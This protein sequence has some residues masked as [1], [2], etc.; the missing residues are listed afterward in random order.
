MKTAILISGQART[1]N[2]CYANQN[3]M[4][5]RSLPDPHFFVSVA[6]DEDA[7]S[8][9]LL[10]KDWP[11]DR[12]HAERLD[13]PEHI[14][15]PANIEEL[16]EASPCPIAQHTTVQ[17]ILK[18]FWHL[19]RVWQ[20]AMENANVHSFDCVVRIRPDI[21]FHSAPA[22]WPMPKEGRCLTPWWSRA[23][24]TN[25][26]FAIL[27]RG[28]ANAYFTTLGWAQQYGWKHGYP[29][30]PESMLYFGLRARSI[31]LC[32]MLPTTFSTIRKD[33][34]H[35]LPDPTLADIADLNITLASFARFQND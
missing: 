33:G 35:I 17:A 29:I 24:G 28:A 13:Q 9:Q 8:V 31:I 21:K 22:F 32:P 34:S 15:E 25:D 18:Q 5:Y 27:G 26:R 10:F 3:L 20:F 6:N 12:I 14:D 19:Q 30:H 4:L 7:D 11:G 1:F 2:R 16:I 23:G